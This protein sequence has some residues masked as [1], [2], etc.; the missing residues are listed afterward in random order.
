MDEK[1]DEKS[2]RLETLRILQSNE[3]ADV[4]TNEE[5]TRALEIL[6][7]LATQENNN[8]SNDRNDINDLNEELNS[9]VKKVFERC[10]EPEEEPNAGDLM[11]EIG[12]ALEDITF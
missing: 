2:R 7:I 10:H 11:A 12:A 4:L 6:E 3:A 9:Y 5:I 1:E 8:D